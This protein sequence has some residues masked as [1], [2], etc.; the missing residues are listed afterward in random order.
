MPET[1]PH[2]EIRDAYRRFG[3]VDALAGVSLTLGAGEWLGLLGPNGAGKTTLM[4]AIAGLVRLDH[5]RIR[6]LGRDVAG[7]G[8]GASL[9][10][11]VPQE[12]AL[13]PALS[14]RENL[15]VF[16]RLHDLRGRRLEERILWA[17]DW[18][19]LADRS[20]PPIEHYSGG[21]KRRLNIACAVLHEPRVVLLDEPTVGVDPQGRAKI[22]EMLHSLRKT[23]TSLLQSSHQ[24][25]EVE[26]HSDRMVILDHGRVAA[27]G[28]L[29]QLGADLR[30]DERALRLVLDRSPNGTSF[31][32]GFEVE[33]RT[34]RGHLRD[35]SSE[36]GEVLDRVR[37]AGLGITDLELKA[38]RL[39]EIFTHLTGSELRE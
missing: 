3:R 11:V 23:G 10:G 28:T 18:T 31:P 15:A 7:G 21:M 25:D 12:I 30:V 38:P 6:L 34:V 36:L 1:E 24:L 17:L 9:L 4:R 16:G 39:E 19:R 13:Y 35:V 20:D 22:W 29:E 2:L 27:E 14:A 26:T 33:G 32:R 37:S 5:G 8:L